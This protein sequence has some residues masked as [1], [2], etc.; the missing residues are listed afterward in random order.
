MTTPTMAYKDGPKL[1]QL[2]LGMLVYI[3]FL[4]RGQRASA[5]L[6]QPLLWLSL[7]LAR[8]SIMIDLY[9]AATPNGHKASIA[10]EDAKKKPINSLGTHL[11]GWKPVSH[12]RMVNDFTNQ[13]TDRVRRR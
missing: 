5:S 10:L 8:G 11:S 9:S 4:D 1:H 6:K 12:D 2:G 3:A 13:K 7:C